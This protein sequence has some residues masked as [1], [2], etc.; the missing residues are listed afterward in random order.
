LND[1]IHGQKRTQQSLNQTAESKRGK[2]SWQA[3]QW[4]WEAL[5]YHARKFFKYTS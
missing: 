5:A 2:T 4:V 3:M 1:I